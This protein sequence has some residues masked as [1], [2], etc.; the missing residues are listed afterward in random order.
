MIYPDDGVYLTREVPV[1]TAD[2][3]SVCKTY[4]SRHHWR[5]LVPAGALNS[6]ARLKRSMSPTARL[7]DTC[8]SALQHGP[9]GSLRR[10]GSRRSGPAL[11]RVGPCG[12]RREVPAVGPPA[13]L[14][15]AFEDHEE[16]FTMCG[17]CAEKTHNATWD[18][19]GFLNH[20]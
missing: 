13:T 5:Q 20:R 4:K 12:R 17:L 1:A 9:C 10:H 3:R 7:Q 2:H 8:V 18:G 11:D 19:P 16:A 14:V 6:G 15:D